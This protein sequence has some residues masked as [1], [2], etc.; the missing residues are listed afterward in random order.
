MYPEMTVDVKH[1]DLTIHC[2]IRDLAY[3][4]TSPKPGPGGLP[5]STAGKGMLLLSGGIDSPVAAYR[6]AQRG[7]KMDCIYFHAYPYTSDQALE[8]K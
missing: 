3:L 5:V 1:P 6:M 2:E 4:Y 8:K 7:L